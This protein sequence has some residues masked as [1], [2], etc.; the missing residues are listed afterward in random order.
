VERLILDE[1]NVREERLMEKGKYTL[2]EILDQAKAWNRA[3]NDFKKQKEAIKDLFTKQRFDEV[4][5]RWVKESTFLL[6]SG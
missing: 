3:L 2:S 5:L 4:V 6:K 1:I